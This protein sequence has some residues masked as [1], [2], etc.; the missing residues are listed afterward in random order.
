MAADAGGTAA[1]VPRE[2]DILAGRYRL[3]RRLGQ[4]AVGTVYAAEHVRLRVGRLALKVIDPALARDGPAW[5]RF[6]QDVKAAMGLA[7]PNLLVLRDLDVTDDGVYVCTMDLSSAPTLRAVLAREGRIAPKRAVGLV[8]QVLDTLAYAH[9]RGVVHR[10]VK[11]ENVVVETDARAGR[12]AA[13]VLDLGLARPVGM[14]GAGRD[15]YRAPEEAKGGPVD[16]RADQYGCAALLYELVAGGPPFETRLGPDVP[17]PLRDVIAR[18][19]DPDPAGRFADARALRAA[20]EAAVGREASGPTAP[21]VAAM[22]PGPAPPTPEPCSVHDLRSSFETTRALPSGP[23]PAPA[24][25]PP[26]PAPAPPPAPPRPLASAETSVVATTFVGAPSPAPPAGLRPAYVPTDSDFPDAPRR[27]P[28]PAVL[29]PGHVVG[30]YAIEAPLGGGGMGMVYRARHVH[31]QRSVALKVL[32]PH[33]SK[34]PVIRQRFLREARVASRFR[35]P[36]VV[37]LFDFDDQEGLLYLA[38]ELVEGWPLS[39]IYREQGPLEVRRAARIFDQVLDALGAAHAGGVVHRDLKPSNIMVGPD[40]RVKV[41]DF[42]IARIQEPPGYGEG[43]GSKGGL[44]QAGDFIG[45]PVYAAP[46]QIR[47][48]SID[49]RTDLYQTGVMLFEGLTGRWP[50]QGTSQ[51]EL[52]TAHVFE[53]APALAEVRPDLLHAREVGAVLARALEKNPA[54]RYPSAREMREALRQAVGTLAP[55]E[56]PGGAVAPVPPAAAPAAAPAASFEVARTLRL[57]GA[58]GLAAPNAVL[59]VEGARGIGRIFLVGGSRLAFGRL[60][61]DAKR[62]I[63]NDVILRVLP[64]RD[65]RLDPE[66]WAAT[67][68]ISNAHGEIAVDGL[69]ATIVDRSSRGI[70]LDGFPVPRDR[71]VPL[72]DRFVLDIAGRAIGLAGALVRAPGPA[73]PPAIDQTTDL[74]DDPHGSG[75]VAAVVLRRTTNTP[76]HV[77]VLVA[78]SVALGRGPGVDLEIEGAAAAARISFAGGAFV[79]ASAGAGAPG[80]LLD[81]RP[82]PA[83]AAPERLA[84]GA[85][86]RL[87]AVELAFALGQESDYTTTAT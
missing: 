47:G 18:A 1:K 43:G 7:H 29:P 23:A 72:P 10:H 73:L 58:A 69:H 84:P 38:M 48:F 2:G 63:R 21:L 60:R 66:N 14:A 24:P 39:V 62:G 31:M 59:R 8:A 71:P 9:V 28:E 74:R 16:A 50:F 25:P 3:V 64:A 78:R 76:E 40:D 77:Y 12:D 67:C 11:P 79:V 57:A 44:T 15:P 34:D 54:D 30:R 41:L 86:I 37:E 68:R 55:V 5:A 27:G 81:G 56:A 51:A 53:P 26:A 17:A 80:I 83:G 49:G 35:H 19:L 13:K 4:G 6:L 46:E 85:R 42:G 36:C 45:T 70:G 20:I 52:L 33:V 22:R 82:L 32:L 65:A 61:E 87:G 75:P